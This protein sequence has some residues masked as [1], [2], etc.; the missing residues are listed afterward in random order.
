MKGEKTG[1]VKGIA[2]ATTE[3][4]KANEAMHARS[5]QLLQYHILKYPPLV[6]IHPPPVVLIHDSD[7]TSI[8]PRKH[9]RA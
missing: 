2:A 5:Y 8:C 7:S 4:E 6:L 9:G 1:H 3:G